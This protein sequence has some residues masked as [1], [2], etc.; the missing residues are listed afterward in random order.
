MKI[1]A[2]PLLLLVCRH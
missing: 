2:G 1:T